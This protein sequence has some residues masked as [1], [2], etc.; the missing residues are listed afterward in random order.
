MDIFRNFHQK[1][2]SCMFT[3]LLMFNFLHQ[4]DFL[5]TLFCASHRRVCVLLIFRIFRGDD[6]CGVELRS[7]FVEVTRMFVI[8]LV[9]FV[10]DSSERKRSCDLNF[11]T[12]ECIYVCFLIDLI[13]FNRNLRA[14]KLKN[15]ENEVV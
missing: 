6:S 14:L 10:S 12:V 5:I 8:E 7:F 4:N 11:T 1:R 2:F 9:E 13:D 15:I 3:A